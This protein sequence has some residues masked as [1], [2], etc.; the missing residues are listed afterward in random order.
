VILLG[1]VLIGLGAT[2][3]RARLNGRKLKPLNI[4]IGWLVFLAVIP[5]LLSFQIP[6]TGKLIPEAVSPFILVGSQAILLVFAAVNIRQPGFWAMG[7]GL[8]A[9]FTV[10]VLNGGW[11]PISPDTL[12]RMLPNLSPESVITSQRLLLTKDWILPVSETR[13]AWLSDQLTLPG[14]TVAFSVGDVLIAL[15]TFLLL[16]SLSDP[17]K[18]KPTS[19][20][21][22]PNQ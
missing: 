17:I 19:I 9:N 7:L 16:W 2:F 18:S 3:V 1:A 6:A 5:Q 20:T 21:V 22:T 8:L 4:W 13:L 10:I 11:M 15:G 12:R 14:L